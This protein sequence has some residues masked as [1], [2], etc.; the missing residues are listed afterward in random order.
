MLYKHLG[1]EHG[2]GKFAPLTILSAVE[3]QRRANIA[4]KQLVCMQGYFYFKN[5]RYY[6]LSGYSMRPPLCR[7]LGSEPSCGGCW[8]PVRRTKF[9]RSWR[10]SK[11]TV[12]TKSSFGVDR[13]ELVHY[14][15]ALANRSVQLYFGLCYPSSIVS[16]TL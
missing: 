4:Q 5:I 13:I 11:Q 7:R 1:E 12:L 8:R 3:L 14:S 15:A 10:K 2:Q 16:H 9:F 6:V